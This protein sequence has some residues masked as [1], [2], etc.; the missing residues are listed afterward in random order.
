MIV[1]RKLGHSDVTDF[2]A[3]LPPCL[4]GMEAWANAHHWARALMDLRHQVRITP[5]FYVKPYVK[6][7]NNDAEEAEAVCEP[8]TRPS[9]RFV[10]VKFEE[11]Q[12]VLMLHRSREMLIRQREMLTNALLAHLPEFDL[13]ARQG[14]AGVAMLLAYVEDDEVCIVPATARSA[15][16]PLVDQLRDLQGRIEQLDA[17]ILQW[18]R[19]SEESQRLATIPGVGPITASAIATTMPDPS[20]L[21][22]ARPL[23]AW[24]GLVPRQNSSGGK[25]RL[26]RITE[27]GD[28]HLRKL[29]VVGAHAVQ[30]LP[31]PGSRDLHE[32]AFGP[33]V[34][35]PY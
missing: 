35:R 25:E 14:W 32:W 11:Q 29:L 34:R 16:L 30:L 3:V 19:G 20:V 2:F 5:P 31:K 15:L 18:H 1:R 6:R 9:M 21:A 33:L 27:Q 28:P 17:A 23:A 4:I 26:G 7:Q 24:M 13:I 10:P 8:E 22:S 12:S